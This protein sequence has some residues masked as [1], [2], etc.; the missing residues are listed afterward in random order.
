MKKYSVVLLI[1]MSSIF[2]GQANAQRGGGGMMGD[3]PNKEKV[4]A[5][6]IGFLTDYLDLTSE[7]AKNF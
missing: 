3:R 5:M 1:L 4:D 2:I 6:K 7:E